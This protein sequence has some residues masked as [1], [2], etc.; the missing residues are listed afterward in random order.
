MP[1]ARGKTT[2]TSARRRVHRY[3]S[4][5]S[6]QTIPERLKR[7]LIES[8]HLMWENWEEATP[9]EIYCEIPTM[10][11][12]E[13]K[14]V[15]TEEWP[16]YIGYMK[17]MCKLY[18]NY[19]GLTLQSEKDSLITEYVL[20]GY[21]K[22]VLEQV[23]EVAANCAGGIYLSCPMVRACL[24]GDFSSWV[25]KWKVAYHVGEADGNELVS[26]S[27][28]ADNLFISNGAN[29]LFSIRTL[30]D[31]SFQSVTNPLNFWW[32]YNYGNMCSLLGKYCVYV[33]D[34]GGVPKLKIWKDGVLQQTIDLSQAPISWTNTGYDYTATIS[35]N[36]EYILVDNGNV[37]EYALFEGS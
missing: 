13:F 29:I 36:G 22:E 21:D 35:Q 2:R 7:M 11:E 20:R 19:T 12:L 8:P 3:R 17:E 23:Q 32:V 18:R 34:E 24:E 31:G 26:V 1:R 4:K 25:S 9:P 5:W 16:Y 15:P 14:G 27:E 33:V 10:A 28:T 6:A 37:N 30:S